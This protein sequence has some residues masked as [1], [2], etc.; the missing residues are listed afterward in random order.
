MSIS[1]SP[2]GPWF[3]VVLAAL[4]VLILTVWAYDQRLRGTSG[5][6]RFVALTLRL[7]AVMLCLLAA[8]RPSVLLQEKKKQPASLVFVL[9]DSTSMKINDAGQ[10]KTRYGRA[11][12]TLAQARKVAETLGPNLDVRTY[13]F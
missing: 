5:R 3:L 4:T 8:L 2:I 1:L 12:S 13:R 6:W 9:D 10:G 11:L 7:L